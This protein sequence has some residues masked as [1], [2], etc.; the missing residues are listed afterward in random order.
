MNISLHVL[1]HTSALPFNVVD[2]CFMFAFICIA[3]LAICCAELVLSHSKRLCINHIFHLHKVIDIYSFCP[4]SVSKNIRDLIQ[5]RYTNRIRIA[6]WSMAQIQTELD[7]NDLMTVRLRNSRKREKT[8]NERTKFIIISFILPPEFAQC[9]CNTRHVL[10][11]INWSNYINCIAFVRR[12][13]FVC[14]DSYFLHQK[15]AS[16]WVTTQ[17]IKEKRERTDTKI[18]HIFFD[19]LCSKMRIFVQLVRA[20]CVWCGRC[21]AL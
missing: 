5:N 20:E 19:T 16:F 10:N 1:V 9:Y 21:C 17:M 12:A 7:T 4:Y 14:V 13:F 6:I 15:P 2:E 11:Q 3:L 18:R 8:A